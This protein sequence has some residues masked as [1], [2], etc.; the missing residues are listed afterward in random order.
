MGDPAH[1]LEVVAILIS[2]VIREPERPKLTLK[3]FTPQN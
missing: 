2:S 3:H 1:S